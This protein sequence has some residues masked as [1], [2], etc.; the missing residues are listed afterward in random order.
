MFRPELRNAPPP[1]AA[2]E[3]KQLLTAY[4]QKARCE[5]ALRDFPAARATAERAVRLRQWEDERL[6]TEFGLHQ[7][8]LGA[9]DLAETLEAVARAAAALQRADAALAGGRAEE[10]LDLGSEALLALEK[11]AWSA[12]LPLRAELHAL[13]AE[14]L[15]CREDHEAA[16]A[17][18]ERARAL[19]S[20]CARAR[21]VAAPRSPRGV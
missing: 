6:R 3:S 2:R 10:A 16:D 5:L 1:D 17:E 8:L 21:R 7:G 9:D 11:R 4:R 18:A 15:R 12:A 14:A 19:D 13:R 20:G